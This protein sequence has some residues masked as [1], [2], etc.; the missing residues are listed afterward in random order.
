MQLYIKSGGNVGDITTTRT[1]NTNFTT[2]INI[3]TVL[4][5]THIII[6]IISQQL[7]LLH[8]KQEILSIWIINQ[9]IYR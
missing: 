3:L 2:N 4:I 1:I 9:H 8:T 7:I 5:T 6:L